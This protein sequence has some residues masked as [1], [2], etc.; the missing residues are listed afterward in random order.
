[1]LAGLVNGLTLAMP[2]SCPFRKSYP[3]VMVVVPSTDPAD[4]ELADALGLHARMFVP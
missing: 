3:D 1:M 2:Q 4:A